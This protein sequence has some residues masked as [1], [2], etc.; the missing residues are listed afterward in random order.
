MWDAATTADP[1]GIFNPASL[2]DV[3]QR[4]L[5]ALSDTSLADSLRRYT[6]NLYSIR[7]IATGRTVF[8]IGDIVESKRNITEGIEFSQKAKELT[9]EGA[10]LESTWSRREFNNGVRAGEEIATPTGLHSP[11]QPLPGS[12]DG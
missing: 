11:G 6:L 2:T 5:R 1:S 8:V 4:G 3:E 12:Q 7:G 10:V 9:R